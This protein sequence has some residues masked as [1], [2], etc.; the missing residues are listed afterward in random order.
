MQDVDG[1]SQGGAVNF[2]K[3]ITFND[4][5]PNGTMNY[6]SSAS[7][8][9]AIVITLTGRDSTGVIQTEAKTLNGTTVV[10]GTQTFERLMKGLVSGGTAGGD[11]AAISNTAVVIGTAQAGAAASSSASASLTLASGAGASCSIGMVVRITSGTGANQLRRIIAISGD[12]VS[13]NRDWGTVP[14]SSSGYGVYHGMLFDS[15]PN[16]I[17]EIRRPF[18]NAAADV[19]G[20]STRTYYEKVFAVDNNATTAL[21]TASIIKQADP[22]AGTLDFALCS[23]LNDTGSVANRQT[24]PASGITAF[25]S[26][27][28]PQSIN[29][30]SPQNLPSGAAPNAAGAQGV[31][32]RLTLPA[33]TAATKSAFT[34]RITGAT[35]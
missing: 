16:Q 11:V 26:G 25:S 30:P 2:A 21:T 33:G 19:A 32:L 9:T 6:V 20:G 31:W 15:A 8:D 10:S 18:Y 34:L 24:A 14:T 23:A 29:V 5:S 27:A 35:V 4:L 28:A 17:T 1:A 3:L 22:S 13:V 12:T 7:G